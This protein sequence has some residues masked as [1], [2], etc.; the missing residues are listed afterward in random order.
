MA[1]TKL[2]RTQGGRGNALPLLST[3][4]FKNTTRLLPSKFSPFDPAEAP[5]SRLADNAGAL[6][7]ISEVEN[8]ADPLVRAENNLL[9]GISPQELVAHVPFAGVINAALTYTSDGGSRFNNK[10]RGAWYAAKSVATSRTEVIFHAAARLAAME[11]FNDEMSFDEY[12]ADFSGDYHDLRISPGF[13]ATLAPDSYVQ[14]Q[15]LAEALLAYGSLGIVY[16]SVRH[17]GGVCIAGF[18]PALVTHVRKGRTF[19]FRWAGSSKPTIEL[20]GGGRR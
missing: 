5:L 2:E 10:D 7:E 17:P 12:F 19:R 11:E 1:E 4:S 3:I 18:R 8:K 16:P 13:E 9:P 15:I 20:V 14:S 6:A